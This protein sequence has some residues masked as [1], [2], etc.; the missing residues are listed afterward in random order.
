MKANSLPSI[1]DL[2]NDC[3]VEEKDEKQDTNKSPTSIASYGKKKSKIKPWKYLQRQKTTEEMTPL[4][5]DKN[6]DIEKCQEEQEDENFERV[7]F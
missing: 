7:R 5:D 6:F 3:E 1:L 2:E 4:E